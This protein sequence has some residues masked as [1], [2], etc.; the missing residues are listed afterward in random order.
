MNMLIQAHCT[1]GENPLWDDRK[2]CLYWTDIGGGTLHRYK[3]ARH[4][5]IY[6]GDNHSEKVGGFTL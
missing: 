2:A 1:L 3:D 4:E 5:I 6:R